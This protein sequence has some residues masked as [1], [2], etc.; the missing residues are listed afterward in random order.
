M[1]VESRNLCIRAWPKRANYH[2]KKIINL[3]TD[4]IIEQDFVQMEFTRNNQLSD[5]V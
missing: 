2:L 1:I 5:A 3:T 4:G